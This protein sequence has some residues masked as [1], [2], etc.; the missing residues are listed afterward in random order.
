[1]KFQVKNADKI[2]LRTAGD[3]YKFM[4]LI[5]EEEQRIDCTVREYF[6]VIA[7]NNSQNVVNI[8]LIGMGNIHSV[9]I[10]PADVFTLPLHKRAAYIILIHNHPSGDATPSEADKDLTARMLHVGKNFRIRLQDH[11]ILGNHSFFSFDESL[12]LAD[13]E[14]DD[15][16]A[17]TFVKRKELED[18]I[19]ERREKIRQEGVQDGLVK[20]KKEGRRKEREQLMA[21][22]DSLSGKKG[23]TKKLIDELRRT[24]I[25]TNSD[26]ESSAT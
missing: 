6:W 5:L 11:I 7:L 13:C 24:L 14:F 1:M 23:V 21:T 2:T 26:M 18:E 17:L 16:Y 22:L 15:R 20:G 19:E 25:S 9:S 12:L 4:N 10:M 8:E 3:V